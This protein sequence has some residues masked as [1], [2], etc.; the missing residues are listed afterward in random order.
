ME[1]LMSM[2]S[3]VLGNYMAGLSDGIVLVRYT[4]LRV[5]KDSKTLEEFE[6][7]ME[8]EYKLIFSQLTDLRGSQLAEFLRDGG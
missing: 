8:T 5:K 4:Q 3:V 7:A 6:K 1:Q 2:D